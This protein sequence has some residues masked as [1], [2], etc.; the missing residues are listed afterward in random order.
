V[1]ICWETP[2][3]LYLTAPRVA[4]SCLPTEIALSLLM[5]EK[6]NLVLSAPKVLGKFMLSV[7]DLPSTEGCRLQHMKVFVCPS[8][9]QVR[10]GPLNSQLLFVYI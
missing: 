2:G 3:Y 1:R 5:V 9:G 6:H 10:M 8:T 7:C 4:G